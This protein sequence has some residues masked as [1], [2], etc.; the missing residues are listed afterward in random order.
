M[1][2][3]SVKVPVCLQL[4]NWEKGGSTSH[5]CFCSM[6]LGVSFVPGGKTS[7]ESEWRWEHIYF[8]KSWHLSLYPSL[9]RGS[10]HGNSQGQPY[11]NSKGLVPSVGQGET[12]RRE[13]RC[14]RW[15]GH[16]RIHL[17]S[18]IK[19]L[20]SDRTERDR[21]ILGL[22]P[23]LKDTWSNFAGFALCEKMFKRAVAIYH[24]NNSQTKGA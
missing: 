17:A 16:P 14:L 19:P 4:V 22:V 6:G 12:L 23:P 2:K 24:V 20:I 21:R 9:C 11:T 15:Q 10:S 18:V 5:S 1:M 3:P 7:A 8:L 13:K